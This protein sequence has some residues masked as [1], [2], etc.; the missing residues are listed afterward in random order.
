MAAGAANG[1]ALGYMLFASVGYSLVPLVVH[2]AGGVD[3]PFLFN[4]WL[5]L[6]VASGSLLFLVVSFRGAGLGG[7]DLVLAGKRLV[8]WPAGVPVLLACVGSVDYALFAWSLRFIDIMVA[9]IL[10]EMSPVGTILF[11]SWLFRGDTRYRRVT[12]TL[13]LVLSLGLIGVV[14]ANVIQVSGFG[15]VGVA[16][17]LR[18]LM[19]V[20]LVLAAIVAVSLSVFG[21]RWGVDLGGRLSGRGGAGCLELYGGVLA[22][23]VVSVVSIPVNLGIGV[24]AGESMGSHGFLIAVAGGVFANAFASI[25]WRKSLL[26]TDNLGINAVGFGVPVLSLFW[27][28]C[29]ADAGVVRWDYLAVGGG[30]IIVANVFINFEA[31]IRSGLALCRWLCWL[32]LWVGGCWAWLLRAPVVRRM[33][34]F[35]A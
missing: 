10:F 30:A 1:G 5:S 23:F 32:N 26:N 7:E 9:A 13:M 29:F 15:A 17:V 16:F 34:R 21:V 12:V 28:Y 3:A 20:A 31:E 14:F 27:L 4:A 2:L 35:G 22:L 24:A 8:V 18:S 6:G 25:A 19:G 33:F 11:A